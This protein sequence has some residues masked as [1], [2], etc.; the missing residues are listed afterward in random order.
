[1]KHVSVVVIHCVLMVIPVITVVNV[2]T[3]TTVTA[4]GDVGR[5]VVMT[6]LLAPPHSYWWLYC[7]LS[8]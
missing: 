8:C 7:S 1:M 2:M 6:A 3:N 5:V 4:Q